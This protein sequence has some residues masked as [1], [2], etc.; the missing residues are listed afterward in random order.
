MMAG[1][2]EH[3]VYRVS[4]YSVATLAHELQA[5]YRGQGFQVSLEQTGEQMVLRAWCPAR[6]QAALGMTPAWQVTL[7]PQAEG[8]SVEISPAYRVDRAVAGPAGCF[9]L[10]AVLFA[11]AFADWLRAGLPRQIWQAIEY[12]LATGKSPPLPET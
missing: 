11:V 9:L 5:W 10:W 4:E 1:K 7:T 8:L 3:Q 2:M 6:W 12:I